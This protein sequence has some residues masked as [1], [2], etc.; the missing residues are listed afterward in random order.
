MCII[1]ALRMYNPKNQMT[2]RPS[3][4]FDAPTD[5]PP[6][7]LTLEDTIEKKNVDERNMA[8]TYN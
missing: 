2:T 6:F 1:T 4:N 5:E 8:M 7:Y 3:P